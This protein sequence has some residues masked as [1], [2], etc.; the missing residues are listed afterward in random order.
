MDDFI[1][2]CGEVL[3][4]HGHGEKESI[5]DLPIDIQETVRGEIEALALLL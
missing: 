3:S 2:N 1:G 4:A 5:K